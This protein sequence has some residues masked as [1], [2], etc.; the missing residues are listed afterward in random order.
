MRGAAAIILVSA[1]ALVACNSSDAKEGQDSGRVVRKNFEVAS[2]DK[3]ALGGS[4]NVVVKVGGPVS[5]RAEG[6]EEQVNR[7]EI[8]VED[9]E[10]KVGY[11]KTSWSVGFRR[12]GKPVTVYVTV[13]SL[14]AASIGGSGDMQ[15]DRIEASDFAAAIGGSGDLSLGTMKVGKG[16]FSIAGSGKIVG[17]GS[18]D[19]I[20]AS[21]AGSGNIDLAALQTRSATVSVVGSGDVS[22]KA[23][24][25]ANISI[26]GSGN[27]TISGPAK[28]Q[29]HKMGSGDARCGA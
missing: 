8:R 18:A 22:A 27:A 16:S 23:T 5:V 25:T 1:A 19:S 24:E 6:D 21:I 11:Q 9:G 28:C 20:D 29:V 2:F 14:A 4:Q 17:A 13:P 12:S 26:A 7:L 15:V 10:L 3:V